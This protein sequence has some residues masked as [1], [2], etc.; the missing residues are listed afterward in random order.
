[1]VFIWGLYFLLVSR[2]DY[3]VFCWLDALSA[4]GFY[5]FPD[6]FCWLGAALV[7]L[8]LFSIGSCLGHYC[9]DS[10]SLP[11]SGICAEL[12]VTQMELTLFTQVF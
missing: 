9:S 2:K 1:M 11:L 6:M 8:I 5:L 10:I 4:A 12:A 3:S 7:R